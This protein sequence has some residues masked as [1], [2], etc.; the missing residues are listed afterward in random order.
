[1]MQPEENRSLIFRNPNL[2]HGFTQSPNVVLRDG[3]LSTTAKVLY[4]LLLSYAWQDKECFPG[5][6]RIAQ[7]MGCKRITV[8]RA[9]AELKQR[10]LITCDRRGLGK[11]N[12]Y[13][14]ERLEGGYIPKQF[15]DKGSRG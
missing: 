10:H 12:I 9:L 15:I 1:M 5:Q 4:V 8:T 3:T 7:D 6:E 13:Y 14:I 11:V 2:A